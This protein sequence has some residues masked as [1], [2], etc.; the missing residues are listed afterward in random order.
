[1]E[2][3]NCDSDI[4]LTSLRDEELVALVTRSGFHE[5]GRVLLLRHC[6]WSRRLITRLARHRGL[7]P[8]DTEDALQDAMFAILKAICRYDTLRPG[9]QNGCLF[10]SFLGRVLTNRFKDFVKNLRRA[11]SHFGRPMPRF[12]EWNGAVGRRE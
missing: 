4:Q 5:A 2:I 10:Q 8:H 11:E 7:S 12:L 1:M 3:L 6:E 9:G